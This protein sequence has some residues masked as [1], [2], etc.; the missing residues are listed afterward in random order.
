MI[1]THGE[2]QL[3]RQ[4]VKAQRRIQLGVSKPNDRTIVKELSGKLGLKLKGGI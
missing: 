2:K 3:R 4:F 1:R